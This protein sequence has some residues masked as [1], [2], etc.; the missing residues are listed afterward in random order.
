MYSV[1]Y[2]L[3]ELCLK[4]VLPILNKFEYD[5]CMFIIIIIIKN[6]IKL[7]STDV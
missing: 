3:R 2:K 7:F 5:V 6:S 1:I 4:K